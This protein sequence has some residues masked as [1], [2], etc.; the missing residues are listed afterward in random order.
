M[1]KSGLH[2]GVDLDIPASVHI[3]GIGGAG[4]RSIA[5]VLADMGHD[6]SGSDLKYSPGLDQ[7]KTKGIKVA[8]GHSESNFENQK[9]LTMSTAIPEGN[10]EVVAALEAGT[11][12]L[13]RAQIMALITAKKKSIVVA[14]THG[15]TTTSSILSVL[16]SAADTE[17]SFLIGD[18]NEIGC[19][20]LW[21]KTSDLLV[22]EG[23][24][25]DGS[26]TELDSDISIIKV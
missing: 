14:G 22:V 19:G 8:I 21:N 9:L 4:M 16:L 6:V 5:N 11:P 13:T 23:D 1:T 7:L 15:K 12:V 2:L 10:P 18:L 20:A 17:P 25:S 26:F 3:V 24:E